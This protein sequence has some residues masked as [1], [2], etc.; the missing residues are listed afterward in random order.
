MVI[1]EAKRTFTWVRLRSMCFSSELE[2]IKLL[3]FCA[4]FVIVGSLNFIACNK[5]VHFCCDLICG[6][7]SDW[8]YEG[9]YDNSQDST[10][11]KSARGFAYHQGPVS[12]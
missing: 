10:S 4:C 5:L 8:A 2:V 12:Q 1:K 3:F 11:Y 7:F 6:C 9:V